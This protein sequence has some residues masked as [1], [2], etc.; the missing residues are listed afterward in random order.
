MA[1]P[2]P[3]TGVDSEFA[4]NA[5][6]ASAYLSMAQKSLGDEIAATIAVQPK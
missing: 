6:R 4:G 2:C 3:N 5:E 1:A